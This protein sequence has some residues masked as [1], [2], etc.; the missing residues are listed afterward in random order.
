VTSALALALTLTLTSAIS[1][2]ILS[3]FEKGERG[4]P[5]SKT[6]RQKM[7]GQSGGLVSKLGW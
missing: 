6:E 3:V 1:L 2:L 4:S 7:N 5:F